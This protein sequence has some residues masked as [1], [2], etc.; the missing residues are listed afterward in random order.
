[1]PPASPVVSRENFSGGAIS[2]W[3]AS[4][5]SEDFAQR[6]PTNAARATNTRTSAARIA[7]HDLLNDC[8]GLADSADAESASQRR[9]I[10]TSCADWKRS[11]GSL[12]KHAR[13]TR[14][15]VGG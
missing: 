11:A 8:D 3:I 2:A 7:A 15:S 4:G 12:A 9:S 13:T 5:S 14:S 6:Y 1:M 10:A